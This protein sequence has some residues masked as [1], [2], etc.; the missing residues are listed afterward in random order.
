MIPLKINHMHLFQIF[1]PENYN[2]SWTDE[3]VQQYSIDRQMLPTEVYL[4]SETYSRDAE[5]TADYELEYLTIV[6]R[7]AKPEF[8]WT[9][10]K[11][12]YVARLMS[13]LSYTYDFKNDQ[14][15]IVPRDAP[16]V[17]VTYPD[18]TGVRSIKSY[19][20]Q[21]LTGTLVEYDGVQ[22]WENFRIA[23]PER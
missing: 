21:T 15:Q 4:T 17:T 7:K 6:N 12:E 13:F 23:F 22:Y 16:T 5:R 10:I 9:L 8:T 14:G 19:L 20:G 11:A 3:Q 1:D 18:F 2:S